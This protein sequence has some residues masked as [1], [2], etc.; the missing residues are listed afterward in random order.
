MQHPELQDSR[1][2]H[3]KSQ[4]GVQDFELVIQIWN[5]GF[6]IWVWDF[7]FSFW[8]SKFAFKIQIQDS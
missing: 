5:S 7:G 1:L 2:Q 4:F 3:W 8:A 6:K